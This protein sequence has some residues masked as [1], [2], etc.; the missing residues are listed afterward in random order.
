MALPL[1]M[2]KIADWEIFDAEQYVTKQDVPDCV[3]RI[4]TEK[5]S[6][7]SSAGEEIEDLTVQLLDLDG[8]LDARAFE[9][10]SLRQLTWKLFEKGRAPLSSEDEQSLRSIL[11]A[12]P[13][14]I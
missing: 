8:R 3:R 1:S 2:N 12:V 13:S 5:V 9:L 4:V 10:E 14:G 11:G 7:L 6:Q